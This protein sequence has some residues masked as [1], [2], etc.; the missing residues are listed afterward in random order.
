[1]EPETPTNYR[2]LGRQAGLSPEQAQRNEQEGEQNAAEGDMACAKDLPAGGESAPGDA[3]VDTIEDF[4]AQQSMGE[5]DEAGEEVE[6][7]MVED[8]SAQQSHGEAIEADEGTGGNMETGEKHALDES[9]FEPMAH[10]L[11]RI[12]DMINTP[13]TSRPAKKRRPVKS[14]SR[15]AIRPGDY[16]ISDEEESSMRQPSKEGPHNPFEEIARQE[17]QLAQLQD[18]LGSSSR[19]QN[20]ELTAGRQPEFTRTRAAMI[21]AGFS[22]G[23]RNDAPYVPSP[24]APTADPVGT[25]EGEAAGGVVEALEDVAGEENGA[26]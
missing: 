18:Q 17:R 1:M 26:E 20:K 11:Q 2:Y 14:R 10:T 3:L 24:A 25:V 15:R 6:P 5:D 19:W 8:S 23:P 22:G 16:D 7:D 21:E 13:N 4:V 9:G 12:H